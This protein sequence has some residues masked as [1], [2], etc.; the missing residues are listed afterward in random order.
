MNIYPHEISDELVTGTVLLRPVAPLAP[1]VTIEE[2]MR[3]F[4][5]NRELTAIPITEGRKPVGIVDRR[6][7][8]EQFARPFSRDLFG[9]RSVAGFMDTRPLVVDVHL[10]L[11]RLSQLYLDSG[12]ANQQDCFIFTDR[13]EYAGL[14]SG[15]ELM[16]LVTQRT[17]EKLFHLAHTDALTRLPN[18]LLFLDRLRQA[19]THAD[20]AERLVAVLLLDLD[21][22]KTVND[23]LGHSVG[24]QLLI[25]VAARLEGCLRDGDTVARLGG[26]EFTVLVPELRQI[27]DAESVARK[28]VAALQ[29]PLPLNGHEIFV[30]PSVGIAI[31]PFSDNIEELLVN[32]D[33]AMY[34]AKELGGNQYC[35]YT[36]RMRTAS[37]QKLTLESSL[38]RAI[39]KDEL[40][41]HYQPQIDLPGGRAVGAEALIRWQHPERGL[42]GPADFIPLAE[43]TGL[44][45]AIGEWVLRRACAHARQWHKAGKGGLRVAVN[46]SARQFYQK[47]FVQMVEGILLDTGLPPDLLDLELTES[48][49]MQ[50]TAGTVGALNELRAI[51]VHVTMDDFGTGYSSLSYL[52][53]FP[54]DCVKIDRS[55]V[56]DITTDPDDAAIANAI[57]A[58]AH[59][60]ELRVVAEGVETAEQLCFL[61]ERGCD[62]AQGYLIGRPVPF[63]QFQAPAVVT[64]HQCHC[65]RHRGGVLS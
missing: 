19:M 58:M 37:V 53:R 14:G 42:L 23:T 7:M 38:R 41:L 62:E 57:I 46:L 21:R 47:D 2:V 36:H 48:T 25:E 45:V 13:G 49:L 10:D 39:D 30:T 51:G 9:R 50:N 44:I 24:D 3:L 20:R 17:Q 16:R 26:D 5:D 56:S 60:L 65:P 12:K 15:H 28:V 8:V 61:C 22:F 4:T 34:R 31:Y 29:H 35:F 59:S 64:T 11:G 43:E 40:R 1:T 6:R 18:R 55:F 27:H 63:D 54:I 32:A 52:K 33:T